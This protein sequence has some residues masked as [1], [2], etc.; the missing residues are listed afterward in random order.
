MC[1]PACPPLSPLQAPLLAV[2]PLSHILPGLSV[3]HLCRLLPSCNSVAIFLFASLCLCL[4]VFLS[5]YLCVSLSLSLQDSFNSLSFF[6]SLSVSASLHLV[7]PG[8]VSLLLSLP[9]RPQSPSPGGPLASSGPSLLHS[10]EGGNW[11]VTEVGLLPAEGAGQK[12][13]GGR[14]GP[15][16]VKAQ[17]R[18]SALC[19]A[20]APRAPLGFHFWPPLPPLPSPA[21]ASREPW[22]P[23]IQ[24]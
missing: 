16:G 18:E 23:H 15:V 6:V 17:E 20:P 12:G 21:S 14:L 7:L 8:S 22:G 4:S 9:F 3:S 10:K 5:L 2:S 1:V 24:L 11:G 19:K 13:G